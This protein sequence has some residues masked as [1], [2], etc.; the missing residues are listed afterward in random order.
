MPEF[1]DLRLVSDSEKSGKW[2]FLRRQLTA[3]ADGSEP[4]D[5]LCG[6]V[7]YARANG[8]ELLDAIGHVG[9][10]AKIREAIGDLAN[11]R[12]FDTDPATGKER[13]LALLAADIGPRL[14]DISYVL[15][16]T[17]TAAALEGTEIGKA[18]E[19]LPGGSAVRIQMP[20]FPI[21]INSTA[22]LMHM[23]LSERIPPGDEAIVEAEELARAYLGDIGQRKAIAAC[24]MN[25]MYF[26]LMEL[27]KRKDWT[28]SLDFFESGSLLIRH[29]PPVAFPVHHSGSLH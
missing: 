20:D 26:S 19:P 21:L 10:C 27:D 12:V 6:L 25:P 8:A 22:M 15:H 5:S 29:G 4:S 11:V 7:G 16:P 23:F 28:V 1:R 2:V 24:H 13:E 9:H 17:L 3:R 14:A 18:T